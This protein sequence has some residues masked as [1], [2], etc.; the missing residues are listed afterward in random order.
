MTGMERSSRGQRVS[1]DANIDS[2]DGAP[3][4]NGLEDEGGFVPP[5]K[6]QARASMT[7][8]VLA[9]FL[10]A[11]S[12]TV[13]ATTMPLIVADLGGFDRYTWAATSYLVA[14]TLSFPI[15]PLSL[16]ADPVFSLS[17]VIMLLLSFG[18]Y[19]SVLFLPLLFQ[20]AFGFSAA[21]S[22]ALLAPMLLDRT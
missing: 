18:L 3:N 12:Q 10:G 8:V 2:K 16:Y 11:L 15:V 13:V 6:R 1:S 7:C 4:D 22:G 19:G 14:V 5:P 17:V 20:V 9:M 21:Q